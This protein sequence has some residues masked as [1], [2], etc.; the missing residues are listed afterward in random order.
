M[1]AEEAGAAQLCRPRRRHRRETPRRI[2]LTERDAAVV[3]RVFQCRVV[4]AQAT[5]LFARA[6]DPTGGG[7]NWSKRL[8]LLYDAGWLSRFYLPQS[9]YIAGSQW[10]VYCVE[11]GVAARASEMRRAWSSI[12]RPTRARLAAASAGTRAQLVQLLAG[13]HGL[14]AD[15]VAASLRASTDLALKLYSGQPCHAQH[16]LLAATLNAIVWHGLAVEGESP[17]LVLPDGALDLSRANGGSIT[18]PLF[19]DT[20]FVVGGTGVCVEAETGTSNR[21]KLR[22]KIERY[23]A[24][25]PALAAISAEIG[26]TIDRLRVIFHCGTAGHKK[27]IADLIAEQAPSGTSLFLLSDSGHLHLDF[28]QLSF[29]RNSP[30]A[31]SPGESVQPFYDALAAMTKRAVFAQVEGRQGD[32]PVL[33]YVS[34]SDSVLG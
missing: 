2:A 10:P 15:A 8:R 29:R 13:R 17:S 19:P 4:P 11:S 23:L 6:F 24:L 22:V 27:T 25:R 20:F 7:D 30:I 34:F 16:A 12:D 21:A 33:G 28:P 18:E 26:A 14:D 31:F 32:R 5:F 1:E 9:Q 3:L